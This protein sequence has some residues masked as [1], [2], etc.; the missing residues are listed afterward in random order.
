MRILYVSGLY[1]PASGGAELSILTILRHL[2]KR[3]HSITVVTGPNDPVSPYDD[4]RD[5]GIEVVR[6]ANATMLDHALEALH[7]STPFV[8]LITQSSWCDRAMLFARVHNV[9][10]LYFL[11]S[12]FGELDVSRAGAYS[13]TF[14]FANSPAVKDYLGTKWKRDDVRIVPPVIDAAAYH[15]S[16]NSMQ[17]ITMVNPVVVKGG[18]IFKLIA[19]R[20]PDRAFLA[21]EGW[22]HLKKSG[23]W[24]PSAVHDLAAGFGVPPFTPEEVNFNDARNVRVEPTVDDMKLVYSR[25][26]LLL[27]P[28]LVPEG[29][30]RVAIEAMISGIPVLGSPLG[31]TPTTIGEGGEIV[32]DYENQEA[33]V[34]AIRRYDDGNYYRSRS[35]RAR[36]RAALEDH[37]ASIQ[38]LIRVLDELRGRD[39]S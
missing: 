7:G 31:S 1:M 39:A 8:A 10:S 22:G 26:R 37:S 27:V 13:P 11:R 20:M 14:V 38:P 6:L 23:Q 5:P 9:P 15:V 25:T 4:T 33:W 29:G 2:V 21:V 3:G 36:T 30:P 35:Q 28:S 32:S 16:S 19:Q 24:D 17:F 12:V 34:T 18:L